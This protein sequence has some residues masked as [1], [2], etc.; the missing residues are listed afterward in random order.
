MSRWGV[1]KNRRSGGMEV[2]GYTCL[3]LL[4]LVIAVAGAIE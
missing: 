3:A 4:I 1:R 2:L